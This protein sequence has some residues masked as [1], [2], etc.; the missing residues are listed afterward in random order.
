MERYESWFERTRSSLEM[1]RTEFP[2][3]VLYEDMMIL[4]KNNMK[5][6]LL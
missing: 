5:K 2:N 3:Y 1:A 4:Q 6:V